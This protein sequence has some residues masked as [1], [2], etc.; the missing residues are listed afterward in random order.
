MPIPTT[1]FATDEDI[2]LRS[3]KDY[4]RIAMLDQATASGNNGVFADTDRWTLVSPD[5]ANQGV[6]SGMIAI[7]SAPQQGYGPEDEVFVVDSVSVTGA[8]LRRKTMASGVGHPPGEPEGTIGIRY[9][10]IT[11]QQQLNLAS[12]EL[13]RRYGIDPKVPGRNLTSLYDADELRDACVL[14]VLWKLY[15]SAAQ[16][17]SEKA[18]EGGCAALWAKARSHKSELDEVLGRL[19]LHWLAVCSQGNVSQRSSNRFGTRISR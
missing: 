19:Q 18:Q 11:M 17:G 9:S 4:P 3:G 14:T 5:F 8:T 1:A 16:Q 2:A 12:Y 10:I 15:V 6:A 13:Y 7:L